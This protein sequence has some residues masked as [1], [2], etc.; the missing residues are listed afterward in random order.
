M[1]NDYT[2]KN[3]K[4]RPS[5]PNDSHSFLF[6][7]FFCL[8]PSTG[9]GGFGAAPQPGKSQPIFQLLPCERLQFIAQ[10]S[11]SM[12]EAPA[13]TGLFGGE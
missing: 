13:S 9:F 11:C 6:P 12:H 7:S 10:L 3:I 2:M 8:A 1:C 5:T 4:P